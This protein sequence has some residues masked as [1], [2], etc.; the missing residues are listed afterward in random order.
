MSTNKKEI[1]NYNQDTATKLT[2]S[3]SSSNTKREE[4]QII[5]CSEKNYSIEGFFSDDEIKAG[6]KFDYSAKLSDLASSAYD[7]DDDDVKG[8]DN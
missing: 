1:E 8:L 7:D 6:C 2:T 3:S 5:L 4:D